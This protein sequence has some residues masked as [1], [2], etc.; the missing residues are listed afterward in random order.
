MALSYPGTAALLDFDALTA[1]LVAAAIRS[2]VSAFLLLPQAGC[3]HL[4]GR[5]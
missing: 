1:P 3:E 5:A 4:S 2:N